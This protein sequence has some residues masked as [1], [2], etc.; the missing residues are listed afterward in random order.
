MVDQDQKILKSLENFLEELD[1]PVKEEINFEDDE[2]IREISQVKV[3]LIKHIISQNKASI[4][5]VI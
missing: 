3:W 1:E 2:I 5:S 4:L